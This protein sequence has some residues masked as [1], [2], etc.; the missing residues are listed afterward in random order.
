MLSMNQ[1]AQVCLCTLFSIIN[2]SAEDVWGVTLYL[3]RVFLKK[4]CHYRKIKILVG[5]NFFCYNYDAI[6]GTNNLLVRVP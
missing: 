4:H 1:M 3:F 6:C 2:T 5:Q